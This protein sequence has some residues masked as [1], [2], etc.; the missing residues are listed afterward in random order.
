MG[1]T[2]GNAMAIHSVLRSA[3]VLLLACASVACA[4]RQ[5]PPGTA[6]ASSAAPPPGSASAGTAPPGAPVAP[7]SSGL[8]V[9]LGP[10][11]Q[12]TVD[13]TPL[14][15]RAELG[16]RVARAPGQTV[17]VVVTGSVPESTVGDLIAELRKAGIARIDVTF[18]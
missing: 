15:S 1:Y 16:Q 8:R 7:L 4:A 9:D 18:A 13:G 11:G 14:A 17:T 5:A 10:G 2:S 3:A 6:P 12:I